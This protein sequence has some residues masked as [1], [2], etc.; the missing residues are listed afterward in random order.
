MATFDKSNKDFQSLM[1]IMN[2]SQVSYLKRCHDGLK[3]LGLTWFNR[4]I[5]GEGS[6]L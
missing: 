3:E 2:F 1:S 4:E 5:L 6:P